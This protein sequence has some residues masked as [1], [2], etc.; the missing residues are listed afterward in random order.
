MVLQYYFWQSDTKWTP[1]RPPLVSKSFSSCCEPPHTRWRG[2]RHNQASRRFASWRDTSKLFTSHCYH[3]VLR[4]WVLAL[5]TCHR[6]EKYCVV[7]SIKVHDS[8]THYLSDYL[9]ILAWHMHLDA[10]CLVC[11]QKDEQ[12]SR[13]KKRVEEHRFPTTEKEQGT[14]WWSVCTHNILYYSA[15]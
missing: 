13:S 6:G 3:P 11:R 14:S 5:F 9:H 8:L 4:R 10:K 2:R 15:I 7:G 12:S 1:A